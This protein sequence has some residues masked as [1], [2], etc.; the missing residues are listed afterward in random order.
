MKYIKTINELVKNPK[1]VSFYIKKIFLE[2]KKIGLDIRKLEIDKTHRVFYSYIFSNNLIENK[3]PAEM[4]LKKYKNIFLKI[5]YILSYN[6]YEYS[7]DVLDDKS[8]FD[9]KKFRVYIHIKNSKTI[10]I[11]PNR[12]VYHYSSCDNKDSI[13]KNGLI[14]QKFSDSERWCE[15]SALEYEDAIFAINGLD[16]KWNFVKNA[17]CWEIDTLNLK[18][19]WWEDLNLGNPYIMTFEPIPPEF[20]KLK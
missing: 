16:R 6:I 3:L 20:I 9:V 1:L 15:T 19:K 17:D 18:N 7:E 13:L 2:F 4:I 12:Y 10:R 5:D 14:P 11:K 8:N